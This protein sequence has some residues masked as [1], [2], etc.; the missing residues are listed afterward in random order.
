[1]QIS[2]PEKYYEKEVRRGFTVSEVMKRSWAADQEILTEL[3]E[4]CMKHSL[5]MFACYGTLLGAIRERGYIPWDDDIDI[6]FV[7]GD[8]V[9]FLEI[10]SNEYPERFNILNPYTRTWYKMNFTHITNSRCVSFEREYLEKW[11]G[12][13]FMTG[14]DVYPYYYLPRNPNEEAYILEMLS[15]IDELIALNRQSMTCSEQSG[16]FDV[17]SRLNETIAVKLVELQRET[18][19]IFTADRPLD[20]QLEILYDQV[21]RVTEEADADYVVRYDE[22]TKDR[23]KKFLKKT[24]EYTIDVPF[25]H[26]TM[27]VPIGYDEILRARFGDS[28][29]RPRQERGAHDYPYYRK[30]LDESFFQ[31]KVSMQAGGSKYP[32]CIPDGNKGGKHRVLLRTTLWELLIYGDDFLG[33]IK[34][35]INATVQ[36]NGQE[37]L[38][39][40]PDMVLKTDDMALDL[41]A[42]ALIGEYETMIHSY[43]DASGKVCGFTA[44]IEVL[45]DLFEAYYGGEGEIAECFR[46]KGLEVNILDYCAIGK[47]SD[48]SEVLSETDSGMQANDIDSI[49]EAW[50]KLIT[51][52][53][54]KEKKVVLYVTSASMLFQHGQEMLA[55]IESVLNTFE[56]K[57]DEV[58]LLWHSDPVIGQDNGIF[59]VE[60]I[61]GYYDLVRKFSERDFGIYDEDADIRT[62]TGIADAAYGDPDQV[63]TACMDMKKP[64]MIQNVSI[65]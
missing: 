20:N 6:G 57:R 39:W 37:E 19:Y 16:S 13:P 38:W 22:Y 55:K 32:V 28:Y 31:E 2:F 30:Q 34:D 56:E 8:Y 14:P 17:G 18:G 42:P 1:M 53:D 7:G 63:L 52:D 21:C 9:R 45:T 59:D 10:L 51:G 27:P 46:S 15:R 41:V 62:L 33:S 12:C 54:N 49:P 29:I 36:D 25:E 64:V 35:F 43:I 58:V 47:D 3:R 26:I 40:M 5:R 60:L 65:I 4:I 48:Q 61:R 23:T 50:R 24:F 11:H 44:D